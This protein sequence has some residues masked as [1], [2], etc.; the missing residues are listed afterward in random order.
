MRAGAWLGA[1]LGLALWPAVAGATWSIAA[2]DPSTREVGVAVASCVEAPY[3]TTILPFVAGLAPGH[4]AL[5]AQARYDAPLRDRALALLQRGATP[6]ALIDAM[7]AGDPGGATRQYGVVAIDLGSAVFT[8]SEAHAWAGHRQG[9]GVTVQGNLLR[10]PEVVEHA[11]AAFEA[12]PA[13]CPWT[14]ADRLMLALEAGA[15]RGGDGRCSAEQAA[16]A[17]VLRVAV[18]GDDPEAPTLDLRVSSQIPGGAAPIALLRVEYDR[19]RRLHPPDASRCPTSMRRE[20]ARRSVA[21]EAHVDDSASGCHCSATITEPR[22]APLLL[23]VVSLRRRYASRRPASPR[24]ASRP[25]TENA[26]VVAPAIS[27][28]RSAVRAKWPAPRRVARNRPAP[29]HGT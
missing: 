11:L 13:E 5:A 12:A 6:Q 29:G 2:V 14:L 28:T 1:A 17:A 3:G 25:P 22:W 16:L 8:G 4:G 9:R 19:W 24:L 23:L 27:L 7:V 15:A 21:V 18:P 10:G 26:R 20:D